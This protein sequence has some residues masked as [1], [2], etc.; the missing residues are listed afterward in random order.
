MAP[1]GKSLTDKTLGQRIAEARERKGWNQTALAERLGNLRQPTVS[2]WENDRYVP[3]G[4][5]LLRLREVLEIDG[6]WLLTGEG[7]PTRHSP[8]HHEQFFDQV[9]RLVDGVRAQATK[10]E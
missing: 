2:D 1:K 9:A 4:K 6:H 7:E 3:E 10:E 5:A 8:E